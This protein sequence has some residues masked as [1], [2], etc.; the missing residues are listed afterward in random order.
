MAPKAQGKGWEEKVE[1]IEG[2]M[3]QMVVYE[4]SATEN[5]NP[6]AKEARGYR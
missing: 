1:M 4:R 5:W 3:E 2:G 6:Q